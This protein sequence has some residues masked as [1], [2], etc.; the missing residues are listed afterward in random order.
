MRLGIDFGTTRT[1]VAVADRGN[2]PVVNFHTRAGDSLEWFPSL[3]ACCGSEWA[4]GLE[5]LE[6]V[7]EPEW[8]PLRSMKRLLPSTAPDARIR[9]GEGAMAALDLVSA[10]LTQLRHDL[11]EHSNLE[12]RPGE[13]LEAFVAVPAN[14]NN[15]Q[16]FL[17]LE[18]FRRAGFRVLAL[19]NE[20]TA[21]GIEYA[22]RY[23]GKGQKEYLLVYDLGGGTFDVSMVGLGDHRYEVAA[24][25]GIIRLGGD[26][27]DTVLFDMSLEALGGSPDLDETRRF[28]LLEECRE[29]KESLHPNTRRI[30]VDIGR[31][32]P[33]G[34]QVVIPAQE[35]YERCAPLVE[36]TL[37]AVDTLL[38]QTE[39]AGVGWENVVSLYVVGG[40]SELPAVGRALRERYGRRVRRSAY[41]HA[42]TAVGW[43]VAAD[44]RVRSTIRERFARHFGVWREEEGGRK[45]VFDSIFAKGTPLPATGQR[46]ERTRTY[47]PAHNLGHF[48]YLECGEIRDGQPAG[49]ITPWGEIYFP[50]DGAL[51]AE[52]DLSGVAVCRGQ[53]GAQV[54]EERYQCDANGILSVTIVDRYSGRER[55]FRLG[56][57]AHAQAARRGETGRKASTSTSP[58]SVI[59]S[60]GMTGSARNES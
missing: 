8:T 40:G 28:Q 15:N 48:R 16:R 7:G 23:G 43:A 56:Y 17:T 35:F 13:L 46:L 47:R 14:A 11:Y 60:E 27:F 3:A 19:I 39:T 18:G 31:V 51:W 12:L 21:A 34:E 1:V 24:D 26:D 22:H 10:Y 29:K 59:L 42:A 25:Q 57:G 5:A 30:V 33:G 50:F 36:Q 41:P 44:S 6:T 45:I 32:I 55:S 2:Y 4:F 52:D 38:G 54:V 58:R 20:P 49:D 53:E 9:V 37:A